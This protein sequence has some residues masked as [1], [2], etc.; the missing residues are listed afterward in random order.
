MDKKSTTPKQF[1]Y[2]MPAEWEPHE[3]TWISWPKD[4]GTFPPGII[5]NVEQ[6]YAQMIKAL[7][8]DEKVFI[9]VNNE[10]WE[11]EVRKKLDANGVTKKNLV[12]HRIKSVDVWT[13]DYVP[14]FL[15][16][17]HGQTA[18]V[19][20]IFNAWGN[21]YEDLKADDKTGKEI[22]QKECE[23]S[24]KYTLFEPNT[25]LEGGSVDVNGQGLLITS[26]QCLLN[27]NRNPHLTKA[28]IEGYLKDYL[29]VNKIIWLK[30]GVAG[31]DTD[32]HVD[33]FARFVDKDTVVCAIEENPKD[34][35]YKTMYENFELLKKAGLKV[36]ALPMPREI[37]AP[38]RRLP[39]SYANFYIGN[40]VVLLPIF[41]DKNDE[42]AIKI[43]QKLFPD[44][45]IV[46]ILAKDLV[47]GYGGIH[48]ATMQQPI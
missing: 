5:E 2:R 38:G 47:Y 21:K 42:K 41:N 40:K 48:C 46:S 25:V 4:L 13:R 43:L 17:A 28:E 16:H 30:E 24:V 34:E 22:A 12:F 45:K 15:K 6:I 8:E 10:E 33:D 1:G 3:G 39:A 35:N 44:R 27:K 19:K 18:I 7:Q 9:L 37:R 14:I 20:W 11:Q 32:G 26:K 29:G 36:I 23:R 31:D